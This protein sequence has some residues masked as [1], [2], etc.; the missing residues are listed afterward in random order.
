MLRVLFILSSIAMGGAERNTVSVLPYLQAAGAHVMLCT[1]N[2]R[3]DS[4][5]AHVFSQTGIKRFDL[6]AQRMVDT[7]AWRRFVTLLRDEQIDLI[8]AQDQDAIIYAGLAHRLLH[9]P[10][11]MTRHV[12]QESATSWKTSMRARMVFWSAQQGM[13]RV[14]AVSEIVRHSFAK[15]AGISLSKIDT[16]Y[17]GIELNKFKKCQSRYELRNRFGWNLENPIAVLISVLRPG[18]GVEVL[19]DALPRIRAILPTFQLK[20]VG[21]G[22][23]EHDLREKAAPLGEAVEFLG[24]RMDIP[25]LLA[26]SDVLIQTS[27]SEALPTVLIEAGAASLPVVAT[28]VGGTT[29]IVQN[30]HGGYIINPGDVETLIDRVVNI[31]KNPTLATR[32]GQQAHAFVVKTFS[33]EKQAMQTKSMYERILGETHENPL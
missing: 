16:I 2:T 24:E 30:G 14:V 23:L 13:N 19:F 17:N 4:P 20:L 29:E 33:L 7:A 26:A 10:S 12:L 31:L 18:K 8:H 28:N 27:W 22:E 15:Q 6:D 5:L 21:A 25:D 3:R 9:I 1:L 32:M 11:V